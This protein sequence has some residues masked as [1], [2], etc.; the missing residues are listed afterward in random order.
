[1]FYSVCALHHYYYRSKV[2]N[3]FIEWITGSLSESIYIRWNRYHSDSVGG[4]QL[5][6]LFINYHEAD[7]CGNKSIRLII[8]L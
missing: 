7:V 1:M 8:G 5:R 6:N 2:S 3:A 4:T